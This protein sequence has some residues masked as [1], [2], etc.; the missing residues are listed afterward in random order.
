MRLPLFTCVIPYSHFVGI[1]CAS[2]LCLYEIT[3]VW[4]LPYVYGKMARFGIFV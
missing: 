2:A 3:I 1:V 4:I